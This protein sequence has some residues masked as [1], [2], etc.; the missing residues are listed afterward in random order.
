MGN[1]RRRICIVKEVQIIEKITIVQTQEN[2]EMQFTRQVQMVI[3][4]IVHGTMTILHFLTRVIL[5]LDVEVIILL[6]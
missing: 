3:A 4:I 2:M 1:Q 5:S 6:V